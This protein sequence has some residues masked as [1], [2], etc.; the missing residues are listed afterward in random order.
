M[1]LDGLPASGLLV[2]YWAQEVRVPIRAAVR[3]GVDLRRVARLEL[4]PRSG[5]GEAWLVD[6]W[7]WRPGTPPPAASPPARVD[8]GS[9][10]EVEEGDSG[11]KVLRVPVTVRG[12]GAGQVR[13]VV[14]ADYGTRVVSERVVAIRPGTRRLEVPIE[15]EG[16][17]R[18]GETMPLFVFAKAVRGS[19][20]AGDWTGDVT[21][22]NDD[23]RPTLT[24]VSRDVTAT[25]GSPLRWELRLSAPSDVGLWVSPRLVPPASG[26]ELSTTDVP[27]DWLFE[28]TGQPAEPSRPLSSAEVYIYAVFDIG[29]TTTTLE[30][31]TVTDG[32]TEPAESVH[33]VDDF[34]EGVGELTG[35]V[36]DPP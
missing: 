21:I 25:E 6:A 12:R 16:N 18:Y 23:P 28:H 35:T 14:A 8:V 22:V 4:V 32:V 29:A 26:T 7:G 27:A 10:G 1:E 3:A 9:L 11:V 2:A 13:L 36:T 24:V 31:P 19:V 33:V 15:V 5:S 34:A 20:V 30:I 17:T